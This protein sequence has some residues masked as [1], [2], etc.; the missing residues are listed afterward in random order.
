MFLQWL[1][2]N[3]G[4]LTFL[5][6][7]V[8]LVASIFSY[9]AAQA[10]WAQVKEMRRQYEDENRPNIEVE[11]IFEQRSYYGLRFVNHGR[12][13]A[14]NVK[15]VLDTGFID[16]ISEET[17]A[18]F[19]REQKDKLCVIGVGQHY[20]LFVGTLKFREHPD[21]PPAKGAVLYECNG[22]SYTS[23]FEID[24]D[25]YATIYSVIND[26]EK[27]LVNLKRINEQLSGIKNAIRNK[28]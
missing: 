21:K 20:D 11:F 15:I 10:A 1:N 9:R 8:S 3:S 23:T 13:T 18:K 19:L 24:I 12:S 27:L 16:S 17:F 5:T 25:R 22:K 14:Q 4:F 28:Q 6:V 26:E 7:I 2:D